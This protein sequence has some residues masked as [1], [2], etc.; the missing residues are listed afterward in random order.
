[1]ES[2]GVTFTKFKAVNYRTDIFFKWFKVTART[3][4]IINL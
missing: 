1:V 4:T 2:H 3:I